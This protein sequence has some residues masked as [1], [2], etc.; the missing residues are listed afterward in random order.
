MSRAMKVLVK[1]YPSDWDDLAGI[2][3]RRLVNMY[4]NALALHHY[5]LNSYFD[6]RVLV[7]PP[8]P[9]FPRK[10]PWESAS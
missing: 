4:L 3:R 8:P 5:G 1:E 2:E 7:Q 9:R 6:P 10:R